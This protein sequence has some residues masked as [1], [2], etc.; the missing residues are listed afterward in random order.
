MEPPRNEFLGG[1]FAHEFNVSPLNFPL[2]YAKS[3][4]GFT[5]KRG[6]NGLFPQAWR[7]RP[8][9]ADRGRS[10]GDQGRRGTPWPCTSRT[11]NLNWESL[12]RHISESLPPCTKKKLLHAVPLKEAIASRQIVSSDVAVSAPDSR[13]GRFSS[14]N[15]DE[16]QENG[17][18]RLSRHAAALG[19]ACHGSALRHQ[20][21][22]GGL[23][24][25]QT[26]YGAGSGGHVPIRYMQ[27]GRPAGFAFPDLFHRP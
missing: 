16:T 15:L 13:H 22:D 9:S 23:K 6:N 17:R 25:W 5:P 7:Q 8:R 26:A 27:V 21:L 18:P 4:P 24:C 12:L 3:T 11:T 20:H 1:F 14:G 2:C 19:R 10:G